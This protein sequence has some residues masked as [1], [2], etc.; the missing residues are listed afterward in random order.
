MVR[1]VKVVGFRK[2]T[3]SKGSVCTQLSVTYP[4]EDNDKDI[5]IAGAAAET[6]FVPDHLA[7]KVSKDDV[8]KE[9]MI[10][11]AFYSKQNHLMDVMR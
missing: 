1:K 9:L 3:S 8:G 5:E 2:F 6:Y 11:D 7:G 10:V 4:R